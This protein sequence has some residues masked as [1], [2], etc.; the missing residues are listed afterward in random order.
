MSGTID[1]GK[2]AAR[3]NKRRHGRNFY[4]EIG[5]KGGLKSRGGGFQKGSEATRLAGA[6]GGRIGK[7]GKA[8]KYEELPPVKQPPQTEDSWSNIIKRGHL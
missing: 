7:R 2:Q 8:I 3:T 5:R 1:G 6:K 4:R